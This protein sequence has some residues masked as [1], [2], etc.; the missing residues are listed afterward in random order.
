MQ[1]SL[2]KSEWLLVASFLAVLIS[3]FGVAKVTSYRAGAALEEE[4][5]AI[6]VVEE[7]KELK[8][9]VRGA[10]VDP[11]VIVMPLGARICDLKSKV[12]LGDEADKT[13]FKRRRLLK[14]GEIIEVPKKI[15]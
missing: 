12:V 1:K 13:F 9:I 8:I 10:V 6:G 15:D 5:E 7:L 14:N 4:E 3:C 2:E 11:G